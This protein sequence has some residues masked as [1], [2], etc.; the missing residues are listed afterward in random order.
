MTNL[1]FFLLG[2]MVVFFGGIWWLSKW[3]LFDLYFDDEEDDW[4]F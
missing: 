2:F 1:G 4:G 3:E